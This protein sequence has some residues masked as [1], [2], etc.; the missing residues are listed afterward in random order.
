MQKKV[1]TKEKKGFTYEA[2]IYQYPDGTWSIGYV[3]TL[4]EGKKGPRWRTQKNGK[5]YL[6]RIIKGLYGGSD[7]L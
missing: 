6:Q 7:K 3:K 1:R 5:R 2:R 4:Y